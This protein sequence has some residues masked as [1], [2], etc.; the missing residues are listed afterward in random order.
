[1]INDITTA[2]SKN[3]KVKTIMLKVVDDYY[4]FVIVTTNDKYDRRLID[5]LIEIEIKIMNKYEDV[6]LDFIYVPS[7]LENSFNKDNEIVYW[8]GK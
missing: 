8:N 7:F 2:F 5:D 4:N 1:L 6:K 3:D